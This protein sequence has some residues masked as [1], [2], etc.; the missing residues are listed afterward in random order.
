V[1]ERE[2][3]VGLIAPGT[4][5]AEAIRQGVEGAIHL[6]HALPEGRVDP[7]CASPVTRR[8]AD[9]TSG[10][11]RLAQRADE[12]IVQVRRVRATAHG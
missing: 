9:G 10:I 1:E 3:S 5:V 4:G 7:R 6:A 2:L 8:R 12:V 11:R